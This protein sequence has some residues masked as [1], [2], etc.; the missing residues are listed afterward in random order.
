MRNAEENQG[1]EFQIAA[2]GPRSAV[3]RGVILLCLMLLLPLSLP[4]TGRADGELRFA[5]LGDYTLESGRVIEDCRLGY[6]TFGRLNPERT[7]ALLFLT[8]LAG[9]SEDL[10]RHGY[11]GPERLADTGRYFVVAV[12]AL[13]NGV[14]SSPSRSATQG[15]RS[16][17]EFSVRDMVRAQ[18]YLLTKHLGLTSLHAVIGISMGGMQ[19]FEWRCS[20]PGFARKVVPIMASPRLTTADL[21]IFTAELRAIEGARRCPDGE[22]AGRKTLAAIHT[23]AIRNP[24]YYGRQVPPAEFPA[25][26]AGMEKNLAGYNLDDWARQLE[27]IMSQNSCLPSAAAPA[28]IFVIVARDDMLVNPESALAYAGTA[29]GKSLEL[30]GGCG[31]FAFMC[32]GEKIRAAV[33][34]FL[35]GENIKAPAQR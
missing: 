11:I 17:P 21:L 33:A 27:A 19:A 10:A 25:L 8:W 29:R 20:Y 2:S 28:E 24:G 14:S 26:L 16:F 30:T 9:T 15:G 6:R 5:A 3:W 34:A 32:E 31:H 4:G 7:N 13:G 1:K 35:N 23:Y 18:H 12:D 22:I